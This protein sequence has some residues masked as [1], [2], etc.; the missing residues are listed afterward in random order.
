MN[1]KA[2]LEERTKLS[3]IIHGERFSRKAALE[4]AGEMLKPLTACSI[5][6]SAYG[7][8]LLDAERTTGSLLQNCLAAKKERS[9]AVNTSFEDARLDEKEG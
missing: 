3:A 2:I 5:L 7:G 6:K 9:L 8:V 4:L 1:Q